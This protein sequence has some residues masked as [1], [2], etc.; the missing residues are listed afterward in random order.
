VSAADHPSRYRPPLNILGPV[1]DGEV[2][3]AV[4]AVLLACA[5]IGA[6]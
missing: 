6:R 4:V 1:P 2:M 5:W 3:G